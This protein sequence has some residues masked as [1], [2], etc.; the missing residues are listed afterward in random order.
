MVHLTRNITAAQLLKVSEVLKAIGHPVRLEILELLEVKEPLTVT[1]ILES[2]QTPIEQSML[3]HHL[4]KMKDKGILKCE[5]KGLHVH[6]SLVDRKILKIFD[7][8][9]NCSIF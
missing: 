1:E 7:C 6:Y 4:I 3:S 9:E 2:L 5:K 8:M